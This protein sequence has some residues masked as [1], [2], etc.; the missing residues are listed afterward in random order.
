MRILL[1]TNILLRI[2]EPAHPHHLACVGALRTLTGAGHTLCISS[3]TI[4]EFLAVATRSVADR[5]LGMDQAKAD[6]ELTKVTRSL[7]TLYDNKAVVDELRRLVVSYGVTGK[8]VHDTR[9]VAVMNVNSVVHLLTINTRDFTRFA[10]IK[11]LDPRAP[12]TP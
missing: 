1:D 11:V 4:S 3:Q 5:G 7:D 6:E 12:S 9:L 10:G 8:S 2:S